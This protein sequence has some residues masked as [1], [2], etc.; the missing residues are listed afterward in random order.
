MENF[1]E[2]EMPT[3]CDCGEWFDLTDGFPSRN[4]NITIC[5]NCY[6]KEVKITDLTEEIKDLETWI[7]NGDNVRENKKTLKEL[8]LKLEKLENE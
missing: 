3:P 2:M 6:Q 8:R 4:R 5:R 1:E 7:N